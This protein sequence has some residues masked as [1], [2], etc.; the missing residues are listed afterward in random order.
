MK[1]WSKKRIG[2]LS[3][4]LLIGAT[5]GV[6]IWFYRHNTAALYEF[7]STR[8]KQL[9][10]EI[11]DRDWYWL[12]PGDRDSFSPEL[13]LTYKAPQQNMLYAGRLAIKVMR[14]ADQFIGFVAYYMKTPDVGFLNFVVV[15][16]EFRGK[17]YSVQMGQHAVDDMI[18][19]GAKK[20]TGLTR[21]SNVQSRAMFKRLGF[22]EVRVD[23]R[24]VYPERDIN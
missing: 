23:D 7:D 19:R 18:K 1:Y 16:P 22:R 20:I 2:I 8:D 21:P 9:I 24:F 11:F 6:S 10:L 17:G 5:I 4:A 3:G 13:M 12:I 14:K 15:N